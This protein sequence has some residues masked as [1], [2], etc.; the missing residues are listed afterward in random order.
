MAPQNPSGKIN[1]DAGKPSA[2]FL[3]I[4]GICGS[5]SE[6]RLNAFCP[7]YCLQ[8]RREEVSHGGHGGHGGFFGIGCGW[9][10]VFWR[11]GLS[12]VHR[13]PLARTPERSGQAAPRRSPAKRHYRT[14]N[15]FQKTSVPSV[16]SV[17]V[18]LPIRRHDVTFP[19][20]G[21]NAKI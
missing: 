8:K 21:E 18:L 1:E 17:R 4:C 16:S 19:L 12:L 5:N 9:V 6:F 14:I 3:I 2:L 15:P 13:S 7:R 11:Y 10:T 20:P